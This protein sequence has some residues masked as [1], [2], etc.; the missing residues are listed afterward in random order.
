VATDYVC[1]MIM[2]EDEAAANYDCDGR[3]LNS[4]CQKDLSVI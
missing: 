2:D 4:E 3:L 1:G